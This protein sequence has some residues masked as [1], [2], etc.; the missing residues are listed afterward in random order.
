MT[1]YTAIIGHYDDLKD[2]FIVT[3]GWKYVCFTDQD[4]K[5]DVW[6]VV[7][8]VVRPEGPAKTARYYKIMFHEHIRDELSMWID[9]TFFINCN[10]DEWWRQ[11]YKDPF[12]TI[13]HPFDRCIYTDIQSCL[14]SRKGDPKILR[15]QEQLY[16]EAGIPSDNGLISSGILMR[17][18]CEEVRQFCSTWW[19]QVQLFTERDQI[20]FGYANYMNPGSHESVTWDYTWQ[21]EFIH[22]PH[23]HKTWRHGK[24]SEVIKQ[25]GRGKKE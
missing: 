6:E 15:E 3:P 22:I 14:R 23:I 21:K 13:F 18:N 20:A 9:A 12:S 2:P 8:I 1:I 11:Y 17:R 5:S 19:S 10:L 25:Y 24:L 7:K 4:L 16:R